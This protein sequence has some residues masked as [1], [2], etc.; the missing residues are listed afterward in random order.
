MTA[1]IAATVLPQI[2]FGTWN[3][4]KPENLEALSGFSHH[5][6]QLCEQGRQLEGRYNLL[7]DLRLGNGM[8]G[9][10]V[11]CFP[12]T[13]RCSLHGHTP[14]ASV[15][16]PRK[17][18]ARLKETIKCVNG[19]ESCLKIE[20]IIQT[21]A[22]GLPWQSHWKGGCSAV[23]QWKVTAHRKSVFTRPPLPGPANF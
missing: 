6:M 12:R 3:R 1:W 23:S 9:C 17:S 7:R 21:R 8:T 13:L 10:D 11:Q 2:T 15:S 4:T 22:Y 18:T 20:N 19:E 5:L 14:R 16:T